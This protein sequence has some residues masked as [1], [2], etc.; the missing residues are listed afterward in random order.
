MIG[1]LLI[2]EALGEIPIECESIHLSVRS[3]VAWC[4]HPLVPGQVQ[5]FQVIHQVLFK[6][7]IGAAYIRIFNSKNEDPVVLP[8]KK[9]VIQGG[10]HISHVEMTRWTRGEAHSNR[11]KGQYTISTE[12]KF[13]ALIIETWLH[14]VIVSG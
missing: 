13:N 5:P 10:P 1:L 7:T 6:T 2:Q 12:H 9:P 4:V 3:M 14:I 8:G 11:H